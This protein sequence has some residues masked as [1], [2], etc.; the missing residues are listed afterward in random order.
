[1]TAQGAKRLDTW[2]RLGG[3]KKLPSLEEGRASF[4]RI[5][6]DQVPRYVS[7]HMAWM[8]MLIKQGCIER[9]RGKRI[10]E[11]LN[12]VS[13][14]DMVAS[15]NERYDKVILQI[16]RYLVDQIG[17][18]G[19]S[20][21]VART[22]PPPVYRMKVREKILPL[23]EAAHGL[24]ETLLNRGYEH[25]HAVMP[26]YTHLSHAQPMTYGHYLLGLH[27]AAARASLQIEA[28]YDSTN[29]CDMGCGALSGVSFDIDR[30]LLA[31]L[32]GFDGLIEHSNDCVAATDFAVD[33]AA[34]LTNLL[35]PIT[36]VANEVDVW[37]TFEANM[38]E[39]S[40]EIAATSSMMPQKKNATICEHLRWS[41]G[42]IMGFYS[43]ISCGAHNTSYGD[44]MEVMFV[45]NV[46]EE[47]AAKGT[48][49]C[50]RMATLVNELSVHKD[51]MLRHA[52]EGFSTA[53]ELASVM[54][55]EKGLPWRICHAIVA[56]TVRAL[57]ESGKTAADITP[58]LVDEVATKV[59]GEPVGLSAEAIAAA[60]DPVKFVEAHA[61]Q[62]GVAPKEVERM[63]GVRREEL[64]DMRTRHEKRVKS[65]SDAQAKLDAAVNEIV[66]A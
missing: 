27:D 9:E 66:G 53:S 14:E 23:I 38:L 40:D 59:R 28:A 42:T 34:A 54:F 46:A 5:A 3:K 2:S 47:L 12:S 61:S 26:G 6:N 55:R 4:A 44:V 17:E 63:V 20:V 49:A 51:V 41:L 8:V 24:L 48:W 18:D 25:R 52:R 56:G 57:S 58:E 11:A 39:I 33:L 19:S 64:A 62:G 32:L 50:K 31:D 7:V 60:T 1:M 65:L 35:I 45:P 13:V 36:R 43:Q 16:E 15:Y 29:K 10:L 30:P 22:L 37:T 21:L